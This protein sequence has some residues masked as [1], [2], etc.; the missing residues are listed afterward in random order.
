M[1]GI[2]ASA[3]GRFGLAMI[4][5]TSISV[6]AIVGTTGHCPVVSRHRIMI[7]GRTRTVH[8]VRRLS[9]CLRGPLGSAVLI[10]YRGRKILSEEG[11]LTTRVR[12]IKILFRS[13]GIGSTRLPTFV[14][15]CVGHGN[16]SLSPGT[17]SVLTSFMNASLDHLAKR[18][19]GL[20]VALPGN[21]AHIAPR[22]V[23]HGV[24][25]DGSCGGFRLH[26]TVM[27]GSVLGT[28][29]VVGCFRRGPGA[30]PVRVALSLLF[31]FFSGLVLTCCTP[32]GARRNVTD[33]VKLG[34]P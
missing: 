10:L 13:G 23:R 20:V 9:C 2:L 21:R 4:C 33:F 31:N 19:R 6:T 32:R 25:V 7:M 12:G 30:G 22:R 29:G 8:G 26:D 3:R 11:G 16:M 34:A 14:A 5:N 18:L 27:R 15:S 17:A 1:S 24:K 28:G